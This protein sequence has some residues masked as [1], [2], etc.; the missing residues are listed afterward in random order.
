[1]S[2]WWFVGGGAV[3]AGI[4][5]TAIVLSSSRSTKFEGNSSGTLNP[6][7]IPASAPGAFR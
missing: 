4:A 6:Y 2:P 5:A 7:V 1:M 3:I